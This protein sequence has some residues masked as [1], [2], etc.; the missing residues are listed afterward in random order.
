MNTIDPA[1]L[2][3]A[4]IVASSDDAII[5]HALDGTVETWNHAAARIFG[6]TA[7][8]IL[9]RSVYLIVPAELR[10]GELDLVEQVGRGEAIS[11]LETKGLHKSGATVPISLSISPVL[12]PEGE[13]IGIARI[14]RD[15]SARQ[16]A[17][18][19]MLRLAGSSTRPKTRSSAKT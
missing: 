14:V 3:L 17:E 10:G 1:A 7:D 8:D 16:R 5:S 13:T 6:Y 19:D 18:R 11:H 2:R 12:T 9:G 15:L 4:A